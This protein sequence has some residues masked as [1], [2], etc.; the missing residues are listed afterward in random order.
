MDAEEVGDLLDRV[1]LEDALYGQL[2]SAFQFVGRTGGS[3][4]T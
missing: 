2:S 1:S 4:T 3:H